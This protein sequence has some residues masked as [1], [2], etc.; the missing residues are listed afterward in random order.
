MTIQ[1]PKL[2]WYFHL[3]FKYDKV[4]VDYYARLDSGMRNHLLSFCIFLGAY[5]DT[6]IEHA[7]LAEQAERYEDMAADMKKVMD[8][9]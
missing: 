9:K 4:K 3:D 5:R 2:H 8:Q 6:L 7:K 1:I